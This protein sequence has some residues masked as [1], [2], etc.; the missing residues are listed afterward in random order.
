[1]RP[2]SRRRGKEKEEQAGEGGG[3]DGT[4]RGVGRNRPCLSVAPPRG[5]GPLSGTVQY[6]APPPTRTPGRG[7]PLAPP[8]KGVHTYPPS[9]QAGAPP[10]PPRSDRTPPRTAISPPSLF[11][12]RDSA[13]AHQAAP[14]RAMIVTG[15]LSAACCLRDGEGASMVAQRAPAP[16]PPPAS[17]H[18]RATHLAGSSPTGNPPRGGGGPSGTRPDGDGGGKAFQLGHFAWT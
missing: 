12:N 4:R 14:S 16:R 13:C 5:R 2:C 3:G 15:R 9:R 17:W 11:K 1:M 7:A 8:H 6:R 10:A 18:S